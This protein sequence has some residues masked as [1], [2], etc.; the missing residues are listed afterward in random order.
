[1]KKIY[2]TTFVHEDLD[3]PIVIHV[4][5]DSYESAVQTSLNELTK[6]VSKWRKEE[7][8]NE[9]LDEVQSFTEELVDVIEK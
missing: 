4:K 8:I 5:S 3:S 6:M 7:Y 2:Y 1:M 9:W